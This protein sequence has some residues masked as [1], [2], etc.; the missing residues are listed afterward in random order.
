[1]SLQES[2][3]PAVL[4]SLVN[5]SPDVKS[6]SKLSRDELIDTGLEG[7]TSVGRGV[8]T[9]V[10]GGA[11]WAQIRGVSTGLAVFAVGDMCSVVSG[12]STG[13]CMTVVNVSFGIT[14]AHTSGDDLVQQQPIY[15]LCVCRYLEW[16]NNIE[17]LESEQSTPVIF[18]VFYKCQTTRS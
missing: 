16:N 14:S 17:C 18:L 10:V 15:N 12:L 1:M 11:F 5:E 4:S 8:G 7:L 3:L 6:F 13:F 2:T 9:C